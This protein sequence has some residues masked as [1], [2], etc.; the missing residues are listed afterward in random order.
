MGRSR[1]EKI[2]GRKPVGSFLALPK[3]VIGSPKFQSLSGN[4]VK[5]LLQI[6]EQYNGNNNGDLQASFKMLKAK[7]WNSS[8]TF[9]KALNELVENGFLVRTR[10]G[11]FPRTCSLFGITWQQIDKDNYGKYDA[12]ASQYIGKN[13]GWWK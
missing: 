11:A 2:K 6:G 13:L 4:A 3:A 7:G 12:G 10:Q 8:A 1:L 5:L 9:A